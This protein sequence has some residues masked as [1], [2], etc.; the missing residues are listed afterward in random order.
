M[1]IALASC[2]AA[3]LVALA[4]GCGSSN[5]KTDAGGEADGQQLGDGSPGDVPS[6]TD[7]GTPD[8]PRDAAAELPPP[9]PLGAHCTGCTRAQIGLPRWEP[10]GAIVMAGTVGSGTSDAFEAWLGPLLAPGHK[11]QQ[12]F[13]VP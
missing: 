2:V 8:G 7:G 3:C 6:G 4:G 10:T 5:A 1:R 9:I 12:G 11:F 13:I